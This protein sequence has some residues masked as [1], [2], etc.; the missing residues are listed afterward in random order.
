MHGGK[1]VKKASSWGC[2]CGSAVSENEDS[3]WHCTRFGGR[4]A[5]SSKWWF[6]SRA[7]DRGI[8]ASRCT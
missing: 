3:V 2:W 4:Q 7:V 1:N 6:F 5:G 8:T